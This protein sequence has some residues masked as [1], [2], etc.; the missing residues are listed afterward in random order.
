MVFLTKKGT[1]D[2]RFAK[3]KLRWIPIVTLEDGLRRT[4]DY[5]IANKE[6]I[7]ANGNAYGN[8]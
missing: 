1:P 5:T 6:I 2:L 4:I 3:E 8:L 7:R